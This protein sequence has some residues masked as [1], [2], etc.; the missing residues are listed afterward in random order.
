MER[1]GAEPT[2]LQ[3]CDGLV[4]RAPRP[5]GDGDHLQ[6]VEEGHRRQGAEQLGLASCGP[7][8]SASSPSSPALR[9]SSAYS[10]S[11]PGV[12]RPSASLALLPPALRVLL[13]LRLSRP[14]LFEVLDALAKVAHLP[15][16]FGVGVV[17]LAGRDGVGVGRLADAVGGVGVSVLR[18]SDHHREG[19]HPVLAHGGADVAVV[20]GER[21]DVVLCHPLLAQLPHQR[22]GVVARHLE[23]GEA[24]HVGEQGVPH[25]EGE[26]IQLC[27]ALGGEDEAGPE[28]AQL[29]QHAFVVHAGHRLHLVHHY[30]RAAPLLK[31]QASLLPY[32]GV[33][34]VEQRR[35]HQGG[36]VAAHRP[37][38]RG[39]EKHAAVVDRPA[40]VDGGAAL[41]QDG[42]RPLGGCV[43]GEAGL[44]GGERF[45]P[46]L[47]VPAPEVPR[48]P[49][50]QVGVVQ[51]RQDR[52]AERV[53]GQQPQP[54]QDGVLLVLGPVV[55]CSL[56]SWRVLTV[57]SRMDCILG[58]HWSQ[59][60]LA[61]RTTESAV[62]SRSEKIRV[63][64]RL[65]PGDRDS[66]ARSISRTL[67]AISSGACS[68]RPS[69]R[70]AWG[71]TT[72]MAS[73][74]LPAAFS[75]ILWDTRWCMSVDLPMACA[76]DVEVVSPEQIFGEAYLPGSARRRVSHERASPDAPWGTE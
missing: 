60:P 1:R 55:G 68:R 16:A 11:L 63:S 19:G 64:R 44:D 36:H 69:T 13:S 4:D 71:S 28:L 23:D 26:V 5:A 62:R 49:L 45:G 34:E 7:H 8:S 51:L 47:A 12:R 20:D 76:G 38:G 3:L 58:P 14:S 29:G 46:V 35:A 32:H 10:A 6:P 39:Y 24:A 48:P 30:Q 72:T 50:K 25:G 75:L 61:T 2:R 54:V 41:A 57:C 21:S 73:P 9:S 15:V 74:S 17:A 40:Q 33:H 52:V 66:S 59:R 56:A 37:L 42:P 43:V 53:V 65:M 67:P 18:P 70:S 22:P 31:R 27:E